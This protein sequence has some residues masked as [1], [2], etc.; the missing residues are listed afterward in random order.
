MALFASVIVTI[1]A[2]LVSKAG[3][4]PVA[5]FLSLRS[6]KLT[7]SVRLFRWLEPESRSELHYSVWYYFPRRYIPNGN[8][9]WW[10]VFQWKSKRGDA[11]DPFFALN[12]GNRPDGS[13]YFYLYNQNTKTSYQQ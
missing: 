6:W 12:V 1:A 11:I 8:P 7:S 4:E 3:K 13:M 9:P 2:G 10:N 5:K